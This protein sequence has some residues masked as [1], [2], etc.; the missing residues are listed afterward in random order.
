MKYRHTKEELELV[1]STSLSIAQVCRK[2]NIRPVGGNYKTLKKYFSK[3]KISTQHFTGQAWNQGE[4]Y[5]FFGKKA[6]LKDVLIENSTY[7]NSL[8]LKKRLIA[9]NIFFERCNNCKLDVWL[10]HK[11]PL[12]LDH[13][14]GKNLD[15]RLENLQLLCPNC[16]ALTDSYRGKN[17]SSQLSEKRKKSFNDAVPQ[18]VEGLGLNPTQ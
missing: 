2:L 3:W 4:R 12:E 10:G 1:V 15:N 17:K 7:G 13:V 5:R 6:D 18:S 8:S 9:E 11:I 14:N 16:H